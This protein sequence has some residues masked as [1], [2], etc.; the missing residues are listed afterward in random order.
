MPL[1]DKFKEP[2]VHNTKETSK[3]VKCGKMEINVFPL[4]FPIEWVDRAANAVHN[5]PRRTGIINNSI[6]GMTSNVH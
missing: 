6:G 5:S 4:T 3:E 1:N 2:T